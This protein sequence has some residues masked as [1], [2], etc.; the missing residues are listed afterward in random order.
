MSRLS[1]ELPVPPSFLPLLLEDAAQPDAIRQLAK[2][3]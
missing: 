2:R 1:R 3:V